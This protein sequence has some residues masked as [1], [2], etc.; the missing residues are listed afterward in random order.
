MI[1]YGDRR[2]GACCRQSDAAQ[3]GAFGNATSMPGSS[4]IGRACLPSPPP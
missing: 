1:R 2:R 4:G 3:S